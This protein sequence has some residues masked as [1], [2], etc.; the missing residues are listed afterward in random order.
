MRR[1]LW[2]AACMLTSVTGAFAAAPPATRSP[3]ADETRLVEAGVSV[4]PAGLSR[5]LDRHCGSDADLA[6]IPALVE[7]LG[8]DDFDE[9]QDAMKRLRA[10]GPAALS[11][12][13]R[14]VESHRD[15][16]VVLRARSCIT[17]IARE[18]RADL[19]SAAARLLAKQGGEAAATLLRYLPY[20]PPA[21]ADEVWFALDGLAARQE[22]LD[23]AFEK[24]LGERVAVRRAAAAYVLGRR[25]D[26]A[27]RGL[28]RARLQDDDTHVRLRAAQG[29]LARHDDSGVPYLIDL[30]AKAE[31]ELAW[32]AEEL[33]HWVAGGVGPEASLGAG[34]ARSRRDCRL[35]WL[36]WW[37]ARAHRA[38]F[39][40]ARRWHARPG[41]VLVFEEQVRGRSDYAGVL[42]LCGSDG[43]V[44]WSLADLESVTDFHLL[45]GGR[46]LVAEGHDPPRSKRQPWPN[47]GLKG[48]SGVT[49]RDLDGKVLWRHE[50]NRYPRHCERS[51]DGSTVVIAHASLGT[52]LSVIRPDGKQASLYEGGNWNREYVDGLFFNRQSPAGHSLAFAQTRRGQWILTEVDPANRRSLWSIPLDDPKQEQRPRFQGDRRH[53]TSAQPLRGGTFLVGGWQ[54]HRL[55]EIDREGRVVWLSP[56]GVTHT[57]ALRLRNGNTLL[58]QN[59]RLA[60]FTPA[61]KVV[62]EAFADADA[63]R[64]LMRPCLDLVRLGFDESPPE[65]FDV[66]TSIDYQLEGLR[67]RDVRRKLSSVGRLG[68]LGPK[69]E[70]TVP[71]LLDAIPGSDEA[72]QGRVESQLLHICTEKSLPQLLRRATKDPCPGVRA[73]ACSTLC[74]FTDKE[75]EVVPVLLECLRDE[76]APVRVWAAF[77]LRH[78]P[79]Q[80]D[81]IVPAL[82]KALDDKDNP[83][84]GDSVWSAAASSLTDFPKHGKVIVPALIRMAK[85]DD[86]GRRQCAVSKLRKF[87]AFADEIEP[88][89]RAALS[90]PDRVVRVRAKDSLEAIGR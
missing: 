52:N 77:R 62:W 33:L 56:Q 5:Y 72:V 66:T 39:A 55:R 87:P 14:A 18:T 49:E 83:K 12:L 1:A 82:I 25:G 4:K 75:K 19:L 27:Q 57:D 51:I 2:L 67:H 73:A 53:I 21:T 20:A 22:R 44:R 69:A 16:E 64:R 79:A 17:A 76:A 58:A 31:I 74:K 80:A 71:A 89:L 8:A 30:L 38:D 47:Y 24:A 88:V 86:V 50:T 32:Q 28:A 46:L 68:D 48:Q 29:L 65:S 11:G 13:F 9:R 35:A 41:L 34:S 59:P 15:S 6:R 70:A 10:L 45:T 3:N 42:W 36:A 85:S 37:R 23:S 90:D 40:F 81:E 63:Q 43:R 7:Q 26:D 84:K 61:G 60:E 54:D 78:F